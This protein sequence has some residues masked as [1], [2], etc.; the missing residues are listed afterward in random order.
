MA[1]PENQ[2]STATTFTVAIT[3]DGQKITLNWP[4]VAGATG[5]S[6]SRNGIT[7]AILDSDTVFFVDPAAPDPANYVVTVTTANLSAVGV[8]APES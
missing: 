3:S 1:E 5:G 6:I 7:V 4:Q 2:G 8:I